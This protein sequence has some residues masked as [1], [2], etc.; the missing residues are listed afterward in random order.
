MYS[1]TRM[2]QDPTGRLLYIGDSATLSYLQLIRLIVEN[3]AGPS[4]FTTDPRRHR[5]LERPLSI[6]RGIRH[7]HLLPDQQTANVL[8]RSFF[9]N[10]RARW[11]A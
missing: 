6:P 2:L 7:T 10:V 4:P 8:V 1:S 3:V 11:T 9:T 5:I